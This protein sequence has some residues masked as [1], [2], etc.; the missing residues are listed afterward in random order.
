MKST[1]F[2]NIYIYLYCTGLVAV[3][4]LSLVAAN[5]L[6]S[7]CGAQAVSKKVAFVS[8]GSGACQ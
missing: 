1:H 4:R 3:L 8:P 5:G 6:L 7:S 2:K